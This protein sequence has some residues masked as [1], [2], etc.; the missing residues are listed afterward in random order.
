VSDPDLEVVRAAC[1]LL[2]RMCD[3]RGEVSL[4]DFA[5]AGVVASALELSFGAAP[6]PFLHDRRRCARG[7]AAA[8]MDALFGSLRVARESRSA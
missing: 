2:H 4:R 5:M 8:N 6:P 3:S 7:P 1:E